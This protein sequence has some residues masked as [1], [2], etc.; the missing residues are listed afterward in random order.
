MAWARTSILGPLAARVDRFPLLLKYLDVE[1]MLSVQV[2]P[3][4]GLTALIPRGETGKTEAWVVIDA[5]P[6]ARIYAGLQPGA[7]QENLASL[8]AETVNDRL[9]AFSPKVGQAVHIGAGTVHSLGD[10]VVVFEV[11]QN[12][13]VTYRLY[14]WNHVD[15][16]TGKP[17]PLQ[18]EEA[19]AC[20]NFNQGAITPTDPQVLQTTPVLRERLLESA[21]FSVTRL[22]GAEPFQLGAEN[23][24]RIVVCL[25]GGGGI[26]HQ[27]VDYPL[28]RG[29]VTLLPASV[30]SCR[31]TPKGA[32]ELLEIAMPVTE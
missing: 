13:D 10:G 31:F 18:V 11:Q 28:S 22:S 16:T 19:L 23:E 29:G 8:T 1:L 3:A 25:L 20:V 26:V 21:H 5:D 24:P 7:T 15:K 17:R 2:H 9:S 14:D 12:S 32:A 30:G 6:G 4:D 27:D